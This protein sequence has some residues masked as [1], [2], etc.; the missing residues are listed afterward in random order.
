VFRETHELSLAPEK[1][2][3]LRRELVEV[4]HFDRAWDAVLARFGGIWVSALRE[5]ATRIDD[6][7]SAEADGEADLVVVWVVTVESP[8]V[9]G[10]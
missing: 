7:G 5:I 10:I 2:E 3:G 6:R 8:L 4:D 9:F 1:T